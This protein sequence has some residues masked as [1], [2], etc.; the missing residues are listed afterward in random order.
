MLSHGTDSLHLRYPFFFF[1]SYLL[2]NFLLLL[3]FST[4]QDL[5]V[6]RF[7]LGGD[8]SLLAETNG[9][10]DTTAVG[11]FCLWQPLGLAY[12]KE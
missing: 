8:G 11:E 1:F 6:E 4:L 7:C 10:D 5:S 2:I 9:D 12:R 3:L